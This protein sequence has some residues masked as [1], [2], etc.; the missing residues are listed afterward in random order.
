MDSNKF[1]RKT[2]EAVSEAQ[3]LAIRHGHQQID[4]EHL[5]HALVAQEQGLVPQILRKLGVAPDAYMG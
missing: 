4:C 5:M 1:T 3:N 2:Q